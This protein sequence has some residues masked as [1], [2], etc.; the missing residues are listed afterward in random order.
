MHWESF[1][2]EPK[3]IS[4]KELIISGNEAHHLSRVMRRNKGDIIWVVDG[5][6]GVYEAEIIEKEKKRVR[7]EILSKRRR[8]GEPVVSLTLAQ[9]VLKGERFELLIQKAV[10]IGVGRIIP[11][12]SERTIVKPGKNKKARWTNIARSAMKQC[13]RSILPE[14]T[15]PIPLKK[16]LSQGI[17][18]S[19]RFIAHA[20][21]N[22]KSLQ[23]YFTESAD[24]SHKKV[25]IVVGPEGGFTEEEV[26]M[27]EDQGF[28]TISLGPRRLRAETAGIV[29]TALVLF[30]LGELG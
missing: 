3:N 22:S 26:T 12:I 4:D 17:N 15:E 20:H 30:Q 13:G 23:H 9:A 21:K 2:T 27:A 24:L 16:V 29:L 10:E 5:Q 8:I 19:Y 6:G 1:F 11:M 7:C 25:L 28:I 14:I 18:C